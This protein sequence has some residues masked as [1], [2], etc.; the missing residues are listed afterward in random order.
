MKTRE[1]AAP[2]AFCLSTFA[3]KNIPAINNLSET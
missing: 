2:F 1:A 3:F